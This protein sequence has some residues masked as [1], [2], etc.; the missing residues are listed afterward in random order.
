M[1]RYR[2]FYSFPGLDLN[3]VGGINFGRL[4]AEWTLPPIRFRRV[5]VPSLYTNWARV[6]LFSSALRTGQ[7][8]YDL[9]AQIDFSLV[10][11]SN[12]E[13]TFSVGYA[14]AMQKGRDSHEVMVS[15]KLLR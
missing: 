15:L 10:M 5:G 6:A 7:T 8:F 12:L 11:F 9:G 3:A 4:T 1:R 14:N 13:S 2:D